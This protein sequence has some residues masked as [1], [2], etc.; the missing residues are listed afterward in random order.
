M[1]MQLHELIGTLGAA[2]IV[3]TYLLIQL[4]RIDVSDV[5]YSVLN[6]TGAALILYSLTVDF[7]LSAFVIEAFWL[8]I[9]LVGIIQVLRERSRRRRSP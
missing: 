7:N 3:V 6:A 4:R 8:L 2:L 1:S 5:R 9:S